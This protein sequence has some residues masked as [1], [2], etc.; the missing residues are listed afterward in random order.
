MVRFS[1]RAVFK[2]MYELVTRRLLDRNVGWARSFDDLVDLRRGRTSHCQTIGVEAH[3]SSSYNHPP[4]G[5]ARREMGCDR[6]IGD[7]LARISEQSCT[8]HKEGLRPALF[9]TG[10]RRFEF[11]GRSDVDGREG[12]PELACRLVQRCPFQSGGHP[13]S[14]VTQDSHSLEARYDFFENLQ[15][16]SVYLQRRFGGDAGHLSAG[17][18]KAC[19]E[20]KLHRETDRY[21]HRRNAAG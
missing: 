1:N 7:L 10:K 12:Q 8:G 5:V 13:V 21:E 9:D 19:D 16:L 18:R 2:L 4:E 17:V 6:E 11:V 3:Q 15:S 20:P 14:E